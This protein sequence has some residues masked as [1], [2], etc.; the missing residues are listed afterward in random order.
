MTSPDPTST[1][2]V[3]AVSTPEGSSSPPADDEAPASPSELDM[4]SPLPAGYRLVG[5]WKVS[6]QQAVGQTA[7]FYKLTPKCKKG[8]CNSTATVMGDDGKTKQLGIFKFKDGRYT[9]ES[10]SEADTICRTAAG[11]EEPAKARTVTKLVV[12]TYRQPGTAIDRAAMIGQRSTTVER[13][14]GLACDAV[15]KVFGARGDV[16]AAA[17]TAAPRATP[18]PTPRP[19]SVTVALP[20]LSAKIAGATSI[21]YYSISGDHPIDLARQMEKNAKKYCGRDALACV[22]LGPDYNPS[23]IANPY[24]GS[25]TITGVRTSLKATVHMPRW[26]KPSLVYPALVTWWKSVFNHIAWHEGRHIRIERSWLKKLPGMLVGKPC[27]SATSVIA[28]WSRKSEAAQDAFDAAQRRA[29]EYP[30]YTGPGGFF[31]TGN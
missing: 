24:T 8:S 7:E 9:L 20:K 16:V 12:A 31:G 14:N 27:S 17:A 6:F 23:Y 3:I 19:T 22:D 28:S 10:V 30:P 21:R 13:A 15:P 4:G 29:Y 11:V 26:T 18:R 2:A 5:W 1:P 25:C